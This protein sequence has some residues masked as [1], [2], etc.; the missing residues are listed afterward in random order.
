ML[1]SEVINAYRRT[2]YWVELPT[3]EVPIRIEQP[4][5]H[6]DAWVMA[7][8]CDC[9]AYLTAFNPQSRLLSA[10]ENAVRQRELECELTSLGRSYCRGRGVGDDG[11]WP[12]EQSCCVAGLD[13]QAAIALGR[14][15]EQ[16]AVV[17][18]RVH[19]AAQLVLC[20]E[21]ANEAQS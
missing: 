9:W 8:G 2:T 21:T 15:F 14:R 1:N 16:A 10:S 19:E 13:E 4:T 20:N 12:A 17:V 11:Q 5:P 6:L 7:Q 18:G 3:G